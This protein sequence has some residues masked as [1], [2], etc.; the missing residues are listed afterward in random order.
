MRRGTLLAL[1]VA[2]ALLA[3]ALRSGGPRS[4]LW[5]ERREPAASRTLGGKDV[6]RGEVEPPRADDV[7]RSAAV[8]GGSPGA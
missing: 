8:P 6:P 5:V 3:V 4:G 1:A 7:H 2:A